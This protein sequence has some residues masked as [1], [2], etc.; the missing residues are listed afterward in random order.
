MLRIHSTVST[1][2][3]TLYILLYIWRHL[4]HLSIPLKY[5]ICCFKEYQDVG[6][7]QMWRDTCHVTISTILKST[8][9]STVRT[10][11]AGGLKIHISANMTV[12][13]AAYKFFDSIV[14]WLGK[15][16][17]IPG[18][19]CDFPTFATFDVVSREVELDKL[20]HYGIQ[21]KSHQL[22]SSFLFGRTQ[23]VK[24]SSNGK[25]LE[26]VSGSAN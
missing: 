13:T 24:L 20:H 11:T 19:F 5:Y 23:L 2:D 3:I 8:V 14:S 12:I 17:M 7:L 18:I 16:Y 6:C 9:S 21:D 4:W 10:R 22:L 26:S 25:R 15:N 1:H